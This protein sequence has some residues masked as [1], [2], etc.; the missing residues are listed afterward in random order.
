MWGHGELQQLHTP[1]HPRHLCRP[2]QRDRC[3]VGGRDKC[4]HP[5]PRD[6][7]SGT[8]AAGDT[9][10]WWCSFR[11]GLP[12]AG[13]PPTLDYQH[14]WGKN[15]ENAR[16]FPTSH[17]SQ[18]APVC[19]MLDTLVGSLAK[20]HTERCAPQERLMS[21]TLHSDPVSIFAYAPRCRSPH[22]AL[23]SLAP[24]NNTTNHICNHL[25]SSYCV[26]DTTLDTSKFHPILVSKSFHCA[27]SGLAAWALTNCS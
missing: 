12:P 21:N 8:L 17:T 15:R 24:T 18:R 7:E 27:R 22:F 4:G 1:A 11:A 13:K 5:T 3:G 10:R 6:K 25:R 26:P 9:G 20:P 23:L 14:I 19:S 2:L 16:L